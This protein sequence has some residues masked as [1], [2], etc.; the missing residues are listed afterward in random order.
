MVTAML[1]L[2]K[3]IKF[4]RKDREILHGLIF[5]RMNSKA[6]AGALEIARQTV[7]RHIAD[8]CRRAQVNRSHLY[9]WVFQHPECLQADTFSLPGLHLPDCSCGSQACLGGLAEDLKKKA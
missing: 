1:P 4:S 9:I 3:R 2:P 6:I 7:D 5:G 8:M